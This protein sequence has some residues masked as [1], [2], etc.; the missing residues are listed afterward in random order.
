MD[1]DLKDLLTNI[2]SDVKKINSKLD[3]LERISSNGN[4]VYT[5]T[6]INSK[7]YKDSK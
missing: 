1:K 3:D 6:D 4:F 5:D 2:Q 7:Q